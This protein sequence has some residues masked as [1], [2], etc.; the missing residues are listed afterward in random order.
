MTAVKWVMGLHIKKIND[1]KTGT[2]TVLFLIGNFGTAI[3]E[4][5][6]TKKSLKAL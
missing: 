1:V 2:P 6:N 4:R 3:E 5:K